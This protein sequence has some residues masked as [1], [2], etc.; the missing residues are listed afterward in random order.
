MAALVPGRI[1]Q[2]VSP[3][4]AKVLT[5]IEDQKSAEWVATG[6]SQLMCESSRDESRPQSSRGDRP[7]S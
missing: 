3:L 1:A 2:S 7:V 4:Q 5:V 6:K